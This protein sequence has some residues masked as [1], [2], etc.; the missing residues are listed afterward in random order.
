MIIFFIKYNLRIIQGYF[1]AKIS[2]KIRIFS[3]G[4]KN[5]ILIYIKREC[6]LMFLVTFYVSTYK[7]VITL[8]REMA[9]L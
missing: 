3:L 1:Q 2:R 7:T 9:I 8:V 5:N 4:R 6:N